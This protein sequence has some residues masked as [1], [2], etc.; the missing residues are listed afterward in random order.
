MDTMVRKVWRNESTDYSMTIVELHGFYHVTDSA[1]HYSVHAELTGGRGAEHTAWQLQVRYDARP[2]Q[3][4]APTMAS[5]LAERHRV[6]PSNLGRGSS[7][8]QM[9][10]PQARATRF[11]IEHCDGYVFR[12]GSGQELSGPSLRAMARRGW[13]EL[14][15]RIRPS[16]GTVTDAGRKALE[17]FDATN[18]GAR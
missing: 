10:G 4:A 8:T 11:A 6:Q 14:D 5:P 2:V 9:T 17:R 13:L 12:G 1:G 18:G 3:P 16:Y 7:L 15:D